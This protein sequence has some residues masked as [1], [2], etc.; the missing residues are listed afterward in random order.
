MFGKEEELCYDTK[1]NLRDGFGEESLC[2]FGS[3]RLEAGGWKREGGNG[4]VEAGGGWVREG[5]GRWESRR[6]RNG[7][8]P[9]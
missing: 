9:G 6:D 2:R 1:G 7:G 4:R 3:G 8:W 5:C